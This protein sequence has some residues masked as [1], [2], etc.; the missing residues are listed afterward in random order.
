MKATKKIVGATAALVA[1]IALSAGST[2]AWFA[3]SSQVTATDM[4]V[5]VA[6]SHNLLISASEDSGYNTTLPVNSSK[7]EMAPVSTTLSTLTQI[8]GN[9]TPKFYKMTDPGKGMSTGDETYGTNAKFA[10]ATTDDYLSASMYLK[11][12]DSDNPSSTYPLHVNITPNV[13]GNEEFAKSL[14]VML[15]VA[16]STDTSYI[17]A[18]VQGSLSGAAQYKGIKSLADTTPET[19]DV[20]ITENSNAEIY[21]SLEVGTPIRVDVYIWYEGQDPNCYTNVAATAGQVTF[22]IEFSLGEVNS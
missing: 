18:P 13:S 1:A 4:T 16:N 17:F 6:V 10:E 20:T 19:E 14:R 11:L 22:S 8:Q 12:M 21:G 9:Y 7:T 5:N 2:F 3:T 15:V